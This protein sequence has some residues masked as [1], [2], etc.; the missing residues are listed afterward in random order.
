MWTRPQTTRS[1]EAMTDP[2]R[3]KTPASVA[4]GPTVGANCRGGITEDAIDRLTLGPMDTG[5]TGE[6]WRIGIHTSKYSKTHD[7]PRFRALVRR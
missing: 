1:P 4:A 7:L 3:M 2:V 6:G 5:G